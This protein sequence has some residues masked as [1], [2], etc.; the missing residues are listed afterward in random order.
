MVLH[1]HGGRERQLRGPDHP[2]AVPAVS[3]ITIRRYQCQICRC[4]VVV[5][6]AEVLPR[7][8]YP[9]NAVAL[10]LAMF[11]VLRQA[12]RAIRARTSP[13]RIVG[14]GATGSATLRR[15]VRAVREA[16]LWCCVRSAPSTWPAWKVAE[17]A[18]T[19]VAAHAPPSDA[20]PP[21]TGA[22]FTGAV[23]AR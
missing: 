14:A 10:A 3:G 11:G 8:L 7:R 12:A 9:A 19:T 23:H 5:V 22:V 4:V 16:S 15:W 13:W 18:A 6:P 20:T 21:I 17:R 1:G 2:G